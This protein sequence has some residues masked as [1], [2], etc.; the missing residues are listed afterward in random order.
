MVFGLAALAVLSIGSTW[1]AWTATTI[2]HNE[3][4]IPKY[5]TKLVE[6]FTPPSEWQPGVTTEKA[7]WISNSEENSQTPVMAKVVISQNWKQKDAG[8]EEKDWDSKE[9]MIVNESGDGQCLEY[10][11]IPNFNKEHVVLWEPGLISEKETSKAH[12]K[13]DDLKVVDNLKEVHS[14]QW[15]LLNEEPG[16][17]GTYTL[18]YFGII[19]PGK[20]S[21]QFL[22]SVTL[23]PLLEATVVKKDYERRETEEGT[24]EWESID[25]KGKYGYDNCRYTLNIDAI[26]VQATKGAVESVFKSDKE[27]IKYLAEAVAAPNGYNDADRVKKTLEIVRDG[28]KKKFAHTRVV[29]EKGD[30]LKP[31]DWF[32]SFTEMLPGCTYEDELFVQN[33]TADSVRLYLNLLPVNKGDQRLD[34]L[35]KE[36]GMTVT[37]QRT[38]D[39]SVIGG[40]PY[41]TELIYKG[42]AS[43]LT[44]KT[45]AADEAK[46]ETI[47]TD[48]LI[49]LA[50]VQPKK[51]GTIRVELTLDEA[52]E[53]NPETGTYE[54]SD[55]LTKI[56]WQFAIQ[57]SDDSD[58]NDPRDPGNPGRSGDDPNPTN[59]PGIPVFEI[60]ED[61]VPLTYMIPDEEVP[62]ASLLPKTGDDSQVLLFGTA[63]VVSLFL[64]VLLGI[65]YKRSGSRP[66]AQKSVPE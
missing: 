1:A 48:H 14:D 15:L 11:A 54:Y 8:K 45:K 3:Y 60:D 33:Q 62:L 44:A 26:T 30:D 35:L 2:V 51:S 9:L 22:D 65:V 4:R 18:Y 39:P 36:I 31:S 6:R 21:S 52:I 12:L 50:Y 63:A 66:A 55:L 61:D 53:L 59:D 40:N 37:Y 28:K 64:L 7:V 24:W 23:N 42:S 5:A 58:G 27:I 46:Y 19:E 34:E 47:Q 16:V 20:N 13:F 25:T 43:G 41:P 10:A 49:P 29:G 32:M 38:A 17:G 57:G 56:D